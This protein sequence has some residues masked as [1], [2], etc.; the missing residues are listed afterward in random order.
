MISCLEKENQFIIDDDYRSQF[1]IKRLVDDRNGYLQIAGLFVLYL[2]SQ[3]SFGSSPANRFVLAIDSLPAVIGSISIL[4]DSII[5]DTDEN[6]Y[7]LNERDSIIDVKAIKTRELLH[8][9]RWRWMV[10][11]RVGKYFLRFWDR[12]NPAIQAFK[13]YEQ[14]P[15][16]TNYIFEGNFRYYP[17]PKM[18]TLQSVL[19]EEEIEFIGEVSFDFQDVTYSLIVGRDGFTMIGDK[20][21]TIETYGGGRYMYID[22]PATDSLAIVDFNL[23]YNPPCAFTEFTTCLFPPE[24]NVLPFKILAGEK[25]SGKH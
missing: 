3:N 11:E 16:T 4:G 19:G 21:N 1:P 6:I 8:Y 9:K 13:G 5:F 7:V 24:Q 2:A 18:V 17:A 20:T 15:L 25:Y 22:L 10:I 23:S 14:F 12:E